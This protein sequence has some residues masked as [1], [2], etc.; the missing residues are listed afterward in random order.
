MKNWEKIILSIIFL[1]AI[2]LFLS[3]LISPTEIDDIHPLRICEKE[4]MEKAD[5]L[6]V[7]PLYKNVPISE[8]QTW[9]QEILKMN[10]TIGMHGIYH[11]Y[12]EFEYQINESEFNQAIMIF[13][14]CFNETPELFK[15][16]Y[17]KIS[18]ENK[19]ILK[20]HKIKI[21]NPFHQTIHKV[22]HCQNSGTFPNW[23]HDLF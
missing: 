21:R 14:E 7:M 20:K 15:A 9:C 12:H 11:S 13:E 1:L 2:L 23:F 18:K 8:N 19:I 22:Y 10:K 17:L 5:I 3:R 4:Y 6:W 16:P